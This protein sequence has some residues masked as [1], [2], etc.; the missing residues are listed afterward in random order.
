MPERRAIIMDVD[1]TLCEIR[2]NGQT[3]DEVA[4]RTDVIERLREW[5]ARGFTIV[6][7]TSRN[8]ATFEGNI[9]R[10]NAVTAPQL[11]AWL[12]KWDVPYD[13]LVFGKPW[14]GRDGFYVDDKAIRPDEFLQLSPEEIRRLVGGRHG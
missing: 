7:H 4:P 8:M 9:G 11:I 3:Y 13:E 2:E 6:L 1:G 14:G 10:I 5:R 12:A